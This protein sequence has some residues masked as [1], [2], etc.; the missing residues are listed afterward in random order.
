MKYRWTNRKEKVRRIA[1]LMRRGDCFPPAHI[2]WWHGG[3]SRFS[4]IDGHN[5]RSGFIGKDRMQTVSAGSL[6]GALKSARADEEPE[7]RVRVGQILPLSG[8]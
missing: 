3:S 4:T 1:T 7:P 2:I 5:R 6:R 8:A